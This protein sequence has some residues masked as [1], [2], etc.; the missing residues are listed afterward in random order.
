MGELGPVDWQV[1]ANE[2]VVDGCGWRS[3]A[4]IERELEDWS[5]RITDYAD[6]LLSDLEQLDRCGCGSSDAA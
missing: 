1:L 2:Q 6:E 3:G 5:I 4:Q